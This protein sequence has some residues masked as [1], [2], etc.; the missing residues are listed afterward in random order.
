MPAKLITFLKQL[1]EINQYNGK[2]NKN[3]YYPVNCFTDK[4]QNKCRLIAVDVSDMRTW[5][6]AREVAARRN[7]LVR[8]AGNVF[9]PDTVIGI[10][11]KSKMKDIAKEF[12][13]ILLSEE[14]QKRNRGIGIPLNKAA[15][16]SWKTAY[17]GWKATIYISDA[18]S[19]FLLETAYWATDGQITALSDMI[20][21]LTT[22][23]RY[24]TTA[25]SIIMKELA[26]FFLGDR[27]AE[28]VTAAIMKKI[29]ANRKE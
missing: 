12:I 2:A 17:A 21:H 8:S 28:E 27:S 4:A 11:K 26:S 3:Y 22:P 9:C 13:G 1:K 14:V 20:S 19:R 23:E 15:L 18:D 29:S 16:S 10:N 24:D 6:L 5:V 25:Y 7:N